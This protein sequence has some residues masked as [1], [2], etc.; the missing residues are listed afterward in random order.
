MKK[1][2]LTLLLMVFL[3]TVPTTQAADGIIQLGVVDGPV[4]TECTD[5]APHT[6]KD[7]NLVP[8][9]FCR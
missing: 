8:L 9:S 1:R 7:S 6:G 5:V 2:T 4:S 3:L